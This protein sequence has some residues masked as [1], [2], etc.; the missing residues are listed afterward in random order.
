MKT[1]IFLITFFTCSH[2]VF[3]Y[4]H[5]K[6]YARYEANYKDSKIIIEKTIKESDPEGM[7]FL[8]YT[9]ITFKGTILDEKEFV[10]P[11]SS[12]FNK[13]KIENVLNT[14]HS[15]GG[16]RWH[17]ILQGQ[18]IQTC[19]YY[20]EDAQL[21]QM[22]GDVPFGQIRFQIYLGNEEFLDF[23]LVQFNTGPSV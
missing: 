1:F 8:V 22:I 12:M 19:T 5:V 18:T 4:P 7:S 21:D 3:A 9:L 16:A 23:N 2:N 13:Q 20:N 14:C 11:R 17:I 10:T 15:R 6:D